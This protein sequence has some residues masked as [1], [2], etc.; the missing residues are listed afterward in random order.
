MRFLYNKMLSDKIEYYKENKKMLR[1]TPAQYKKDFDWLKE[2]DSLALVYA[3]NN[4]NQAFQNFFKR[5]E[6]GFPKF[7]SKK[8]HRQTYTTYNNHETAIRIENNKIRLPK[9]K[10][11]KIKGY[12]G[13]DGKI[14]NATIIKTPS[15]KYYVSLLVDCPENSKLPKLDNAIGVDLGLKD[16]AITSNGGKIE[17]PRFLKKSEEKL[18]KLQKDL[19]RCQKG[20]RNREKCRIR[21][22]RQYEKITNQRKDFLHKLS[23]KIIYENQVIVLESLKVKNMMGNRKLAKSIADAS[24]SEFVR[25]LEYKSDWYGREIIKI[26]TFFPSSQIC[27]NCGCV[28]GKKD[29][30]IREWTC[31]H[32]GTHLDRDINAA[33]NILKEGLNIKNTGGQ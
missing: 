13:F 6:I 10:F 5:P 21:L 14:I 24:W 3:S 1:N 26:D 11:V 2:V 30:S 9:I 27:S 12:K 17:N 28:D 18:K 33:Q 25:Q 29:L 7:K 23:K 31:P 20:S 8:N 4:L 22:A 16:F 32:C 19:S 15:N